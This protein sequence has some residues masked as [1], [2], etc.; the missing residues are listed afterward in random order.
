MENELHPEEHSSAT[1]NEG[2]STRLRRRSSVEAPNI[3]LLLEDNPTAGIEQP[4][5]R[6]RA[7]KLQRQSS[8]EEMEKASCK[9]EPRIEGRIVVINEE[10][11][12]QLI[13][14]REA[15]EKSVTRTIKELGESTESN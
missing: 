5:T 12:P 3:A 7:P 9:L 10:T 8:I 6:P 1:S 13:S 14:D 11:L 15:W 4:T 2:G